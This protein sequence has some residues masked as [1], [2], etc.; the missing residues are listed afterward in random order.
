[1]AEKLNIKRLRLSDLVLPANILVIGPSVSR[2]NAVVAKLIDKSLTYTAVATSHPDFY[3][4]I[5]DLGLMIF[6]DG[7]KD[8]ADNQRFKDAKI[9]VLND[10]SPTNFAH[11]DVKRER[12]TI[13]TI[14]DYTYHIPRSALSAIDYVFLFGGIKQVRRLW[15]DFGALIP[16]YKDFRQIY[17]ASTDEGDRYCDD[18][19]I[20]HM[21]KETSDPNDV[22]FWS[23]LRKAA[24]IPVEVNREIILNKVYTAEEVAIPNP[25]ET[26][27]PTQI[28]STSTTAGQ[29]RESRDDCVIL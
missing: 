18:F 2:K 6:G 8:I 16:K 7:I 9:R 21:V 22:F 28:E 10:I 13:I 23:T 19:M 29:E 24:V 26:V 20:I 5:D 11:F 14:D 12:T 25:D 4:K 15:D 1:M 27:Q 3:D 17:L